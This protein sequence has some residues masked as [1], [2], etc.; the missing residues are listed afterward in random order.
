MATLPIVNRAE[1]VLL[2]DADAMA[3][4]GCSDRQRMDALLT[5]SMAIA[6]TTVG[7]IFA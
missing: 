3:F 5:T 4:T 6:W 2:D 7:R 1:R